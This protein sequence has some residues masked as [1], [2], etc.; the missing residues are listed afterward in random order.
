LDSC[1]WNATHILVLAPT[2]IRGSYRV[3]EFIKGSV[4]PGTIFAFSE[5]APPDEVTSTLKELAA[6]GEL[7]SGMDPY[8]A[9]PPLRPTD[10]II[11]FLR[12]P[13]ALPEYSIRPDLPVSTDGWQPADHFGGFLT[14]AVWL[15]DG[16]AYG[17]YQIVNPGPS[18]LVD[19]RRSE[20]RV[21]E[22]INSVLRVRASFDKALG[23]AEPG[24]RARNL[25]AF[26]RS[27]VF[28]ARWSA[29]RHLESG[30]A[31]AVN[32]LQELLADP[33]LLARHSEIIETLVR[34]GAKSLDFVPVLKEE[35]AYW[36]KACG[37]HGPGWWGNPA[38]PDVEAAKSHYS[39]LLSA[40]VGVRT[41]HLTMDVDAVRDL[42]AIW[43]SCPPLDAGEPLALSQ[44]SSECNSILS[45]EEH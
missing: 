8:V 38:D 17:F 13:G 20:T 39:R 19:I 21:R 15:E 32:A 1:T 30:G 22:R 40:L 27:D 3:V 29:L 31:P 44:V 14:S 6:Q 2:E 5:L 45:V 12:Q 33:D 4:P 41:L 37:K 35:T 9:A 16:A 24:E 11:L 10:R 23:V 36:A 25:A 26:V 42:L 34:T 18:R 28:V 7:A 43:N